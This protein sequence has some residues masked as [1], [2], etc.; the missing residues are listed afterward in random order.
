MVLSGSA[1]VG[2]FVRKDERPPS[3]VLPAGLR[4]S[5]Q[6]PNRAQITCQMESPAVAVAPAGQ[7]G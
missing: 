2:V 6:D 7:E 3:G 5:S 4:G 1:G